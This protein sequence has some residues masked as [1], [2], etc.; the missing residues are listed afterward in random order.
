MSS[1]TQQVGEFPALASVSGQSKCGKTKTVEV[2]LQKLAEAGEPA[3]QSFDCGAVPRRWAE[4]RGIS[5]ERL[6]A[7]MT[8]ADDQAID[9]ESQEFLLRP[10]SFGIAAGRLTWWVTKCN[11]V[12]Q[13]RV[14]LTCPDE[15]CAS[16]VNLPV[17]Q[18]T[19]RNAD[20]TRR[21]RE[22]YGIEFPPPS[23]FVLSQEFNLV[24]STH[25]HPADEV[26]NIILDCGRRWN[27]G[28]PYEKFF[29]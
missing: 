7:E 6:V 2:L 20:D 8:P 14:W 23:M 15:V 26:A 27:A 3:R 28:L 11:D 5:L 19:R 29:H 17:E 13:F 1:T 21:F 16:R 18:V 22:Y 25:T 10:S 9:L 4:Q 12:R 24:V